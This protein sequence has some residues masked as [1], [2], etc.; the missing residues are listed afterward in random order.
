MR[1]DRALSV[2][3]LGALAVVLCGR[4]RDADACGG[5]FVP[6][7]QRSTVTVTDHRMA[8]AIS[9]NETVLWDQVRY[10]GNPSEFA[11]VAPV[12]AGSRLELSSDAW[13]DALEASTQPVVYAPP[14]Y[15]SSAGCALGGCGQASVGT[16]NAGGAEIVRSDVVGPYESITFRATDP[17]GVAKWLRD[18]GFAI[19]DTANAALTA[20]AQE[21]FDFIALRLRPG[22]NVRA[23]R[24]VRIVIPGADPT[25]PLRMTVAG[26]GSQVG[27]TL[28]VIAEARY[29]PPSFATAKI[30]FSKLVWEKSTKKS[31]YEKL[32]LEA[33]NSGNGNSFITEYADRPPAT[34]NVPLDEQRTVTPTLYESYPK[35]CS[36]VVPSGTKIDAS[37]RVD[38]CV[39]ID[40]GAPTD[41]STD[42]PR[43]DAGA[44]ADADV[45]AA[46]DAGDPDAEP[47]DAG[48][49]D[50]S[51]ADAGADAAPM[52]FSE[53]GA[54]LPVTC[55]SPDDLTVALRNIPNGRAYITRLRTNLIGPSGF[56][57][58]KLV[59]AA[60]QSSV[61][62]SYQVVGYSD[63]VRRNEPDRSAVCGSPR[64]RGG[65]ASDAGVLA[66]GVLALAWLRRRARR[67]GP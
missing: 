63:E 35:L 59:P 9:K 44:G 36:G 15:G 7:I 39:S 48:A 46:D 4:A 12:R 19:P 24:P 14:E 22:C 31:N 45:D 5:V 52:A 32:A 61:S 37:S 29:E 28:W 50:A 34:S 1:R 8:I 41:A 23:M 66:A 16:E 62:N 40:A 43:A 17:G 10:S 42:A 49:P 25:V 64:K 53:A 30:D 33:M 67:R 54:P 38:P 55:G 18:R 13:F 11:W 6:E 20:Y 2:A 47:P 27:L 60:D 65:G 21:G 58:L 3:T 26:A 51:D 57:D 56:K